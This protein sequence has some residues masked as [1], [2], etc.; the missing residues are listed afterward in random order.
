MTGL[1]GALTAG[2]LSEP[3]V[4]CRP[5]AATRGNGATLINLALYQVGWFACVLGAANGRPWV[6]AGLALVLVAVHV[7]LVR[8]R[9]RTARLLLAAAALGLL[10]DSL[11]LNLGVFR[12]PSGTPL[13]GLAPPWI[14]VLWLQFATLL[15]FG[16]RW[17]SGRYGLAA[18]LGFLG[19]PLSFW[20]GERLGAIEFASPAAY[21][22]LACV[23][24]L[25]MPTLIWLGDRLQPRP[26]GYR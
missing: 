9:G 6:G 12:Y 2:S 21:L 23:W 25:A 14:V 8:D 5:A 1:V 19:G 24:S 7:A 15:H 17:L 10:L 13:E 26:G 18:L 16:L 3:A 20:G 11:Q 22:S 4:A